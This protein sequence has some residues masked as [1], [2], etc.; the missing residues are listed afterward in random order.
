M[1][2]T[3]E[4]IKIDWF[5][6]SPILGKKALFLTGNSLLVNPCLETNP[7]DP[8]NSNTIRVILIQKEE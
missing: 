7:V 6:I 3:T 4:V 2:H 1:V 8:S 5:R